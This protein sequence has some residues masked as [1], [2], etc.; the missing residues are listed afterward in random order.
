MRHDAAGYAVAWQSIMIERQTHRETK[1]ERRHLERFFSTDMP[2]THFL[3]NILPFSLA[4]LLPVLLLCVSL[5]Q[6]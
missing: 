6:H 5:Y 4:G 2:G 1:V 3:R